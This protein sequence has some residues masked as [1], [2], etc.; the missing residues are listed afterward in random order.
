[1]KDYL[2]QKSILLS[3]VFPILLIQVT[4]AQQLVTDPTLIISEPST[5]RPPVFSTYTD[6]KFNT[7]ITRITDAAQLNSG[8]TVPI[9][10][11]LQ[12]WNAD[13]S[14]ILLQ[15]NQIM[16][17]NTYTVLHELDYYW[18]AYGEG[19]RWSPTE[20]NVLYY[21]GGLLDGY[22]DPDG[23]ACG[24][25]SGRL[26]RYRLIP[27]NPITAQRELVRCFSEYTEILKDPSWEELSENGQYVALVGRRPD[28]KMEVFAYDIFNDIKHTPR[29]SPGAVDWVSI[30]PSGKYVLIMG[31]TPDNRYFGL[32]AYDRNTM[33]YLG[34]VTTGHGHGD[35][36][37][38]EKGDE[39]YVYTNADNAYF[40]SDNHYIVKSRIP[41][42]V[43]FDNNGYPDETAILSSGLSVPLLQ[44]EWS[45]SIHISCRNSAN[46]EWCVVSILGSV[47][48]GWQAL[49]D[50]IFLLY[51]NSTVQNPNVIR[52]AHH[53]SD[54]NYAEVCGLG[55]YWADSHA[56]VTGDGKH[57]IFGSTWEENCQID[58]Y[59]IDLSNLGG[60]PVP[61]ELVS[62]TVNS[63]NDH[64]IL[65]W[66]TASETN[67]Y[68]FE[69]ER[70][71]GN[72]DYEV[73]GFVPG[74]GTTSIWQSYSF[75]DKNVQSSVKYSYRLK[76]IDLDGTFEYSQELYIEVGFPTEFR[77]LGNYP[78]PF[79]PLTTISFEI[80]FKSKITLIVYDITGKTVRTLLANEFKEA[81]RYSL[82]FDA[83][84][85]TS[86]LYFYRLSAGDTW[87]HT[88]RMLLIK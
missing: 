25:G 32:A 40:F 70:R 77:L 26:M 85:L 47:S 86:G 30:S 61:I 45:H 41:N 53:R 52:L 87:T 57:I 24:S 18:P 73:L 56:T 88:G 83:T 80:P 58:S 35:L 42:G 51:L 64:V 44:L 81:G 12:A 49:E 10:S 16:N 82:P 39:Y 37:M 74:N 50:E 5:P 11:Q 19:P 14:M 65:N 75:V 54:Y 27:G 46:P 67:N 4:T 13:Q 29:V 66:T 60:T 84:D 78:N 1:M 59:I 79:N 48:N 72:A 28:G 3:F 21:T 71:I 22:S 68:G 9:Y 31:T 38:D 36:I 6:P 62:F 7:Q 15:T 63:N 20:P 76:Q 69:V 43:V 2:M 23:F 17:A 55:G 33:D 8:I 34:L